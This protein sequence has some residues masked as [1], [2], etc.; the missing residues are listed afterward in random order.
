MLKKHQSIKKTELTAKKTLEM[1]V[2]PSVDISTWDN[3]EVVKY[4]EA[5]L[6]ELCNRMESIKHLTDQAQKDKFSRL[7][8]IFAPQLKGR[9]TF[10]N[11]KLADFTKLSSTHQL[12][13]S[14][15][16]A[17]NWRENRM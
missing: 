16:E 17:N 5:K 11:E 15:L 2:R 6:T 8:K 4:S 9:K 14:L 7:C 13:L 1:Y 10:F 12:S 3:V